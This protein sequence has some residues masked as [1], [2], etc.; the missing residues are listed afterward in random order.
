MAFVLADR[1][2][3]TTNTTGTGAGI[4][5]LGRNSD[6]EDKY[7]YLY[8]YTQDNGAGGNFGWRMKGTGAG[9]LY[10][11]FDFYHNGSSSI[12]QGLTSSFLIKDASGDTRISLGD[13]T[14]LTFSEVITDSIMF[15]TSPGV[16]KIITS[17][18]AGNFA[19]TYVY[20]CNNF[21]VCIYRRIKFCACW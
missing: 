7:S 18:A 3:D 6:D 10:N 15:T 2:R 14:G 17:D 5:Y 9:T 20:N 13:A 4:G 21:I 8:G 1:V 12:F 11:M 16:D 19:W